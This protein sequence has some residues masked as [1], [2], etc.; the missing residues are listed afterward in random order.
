VF[1][2]GDPKHRAAVEQI[3]TVTA[4]QI[5]DAR[6]AMDEGEFGAD[7]WVQ[8]H[9]A[10][11]RRLALMLSIHDDASILDGTVV[12]LPPDGEDTKLSLAL[13]E[14]DAKADAI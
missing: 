13:R 14:R 5:E 12:T 7:L 8:D 6:A 9:E 11:L 1:I 10:S 3:H 4:L 2:K